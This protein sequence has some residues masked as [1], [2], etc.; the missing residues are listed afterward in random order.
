VVE[1]SAFVETDGNV[2]LAGERRALQHDVFLAEE[3][4]KREGRA[5]L[6]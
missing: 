6:H 4:E 5:L 1:C 2:D 3:V